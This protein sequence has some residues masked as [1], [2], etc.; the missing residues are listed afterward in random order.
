MTF[1]W[2]NIFRAFSTRWTVNIAWLTKSRQSAR[3]FIQSSELGLPHPLTR[4]RVSLPPLVPGEG[5]TCLRERGSQFGQGD[6]HCGTLGIIVLCED[7][8][9]NQQVR[10][11]NVIS[12]LLDFM[13]SFLICKLLYVSCVS[14]SLPWK[15]GI[16]GANAFCHLY[17]S[18]LQ[19]PRQCL[20]PTCHLSTLN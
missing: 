5:H 3:L 12:A 11:T 20:T 1:A 15:V 19:P 13:D 6:R 16:N 14:I 17:P 9:W 10:E 18:S 4:R 8:S 7:T 2:P